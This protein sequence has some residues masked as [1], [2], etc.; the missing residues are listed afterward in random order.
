M[1]ALRLP[2]FFIKKRKFCHYLQTYMTDWLSSVKHIRRYFEMSISV[3]SH[4]IIHRRMNVIHVWNNMMNWTIKHHKIS[5]YGFFAVFQ[6]FW[7]HAIA[8]VRGTYWILSHYSLKLLLD[9]H[10]HHSVL[11]VCKR[12]LSS[13]NH[14]QVVPNLY[15]FHTIFFFFFFPTM[16]VN[17]Y[18][19]LSG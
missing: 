17:G 11:I 7:S 8:F 18:R 12:A 3:L 10:C 14:P 9:S 15:D 5:L 19:Q 13:L 4:F 16:E 6:V 2:W 1:F